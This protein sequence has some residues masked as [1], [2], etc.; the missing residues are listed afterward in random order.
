MQ[1]KMQ[2]ISLCHTELNEERLE[3]LGSAV[4]ALL[5]TEANFE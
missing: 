5:N 1:L 4:F 2:L 3:S